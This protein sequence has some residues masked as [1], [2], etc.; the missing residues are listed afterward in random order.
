MLFCVSN[1]SSILFDAIRLQLSWF[2][3]LRS[4]VS[5]RS[6]FHVEVK[7]N[8][9]GSTPKHGFNVPS[10]LLVVLTQTTVPL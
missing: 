7:K 3:W 1:R 9:L 4:L 8:P 10:K 6:K 2:W 5:H